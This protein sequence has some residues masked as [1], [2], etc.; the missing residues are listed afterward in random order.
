MCTGVE[1]ALMAA[2]AGGQLIQA[3]ESQRQ[4]DAMVSASNDRLNQFLDRNQ[5][6]SDEAAELFR[7]RQSAAEADQ[8]GQS[9]N[10]AV[11]TRETKATEA[12]DSTAPATATPTTGSA[13]SVIGKVY[14]S[15]GA[16][17][18]D[19]SKTR[20]RAM[21]KTSGFGDALFGQ[22]LAT[23]NAGRKIG[24]I[25]EFASSD[26]AMLPHYQ[27]LAAAAAGQRNR[28]GP[29]GALL[30][31]LGTAGGYYYGSRP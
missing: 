12:I 3:N 20:A 2:G 1:L 13:A 10:E 31:G 22:D 19:A 27:D 21:A 15:E 25:G 29:F 5:Q 26:A 24:T 17:G 18:R 28:P 23:A 16:K 7:E 6:R 14:E 30:S 4:Q 9:R 8:A 11:Q